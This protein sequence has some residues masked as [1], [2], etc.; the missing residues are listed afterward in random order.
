MRTSRRPG[1]AART[2]P[3]IRLIPLFVGFVGFVGVGG[4]GTPGKK[5]IRPEF[6]LHDPS[7]TR[8]TEAV[9]DVSLRRD[10][11]HVP[12]LISLLD[13]DDPAVRMA[14]GTTLKELTGHDT[15]YRPYA[16]LEERRR[17]VD[18]WRAWWAARGAGRP[19][20]PPARPDGGPA[21]AGGDR[22]R[23]P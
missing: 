1:R 9:L 3:A 11:K 17:H 5:P 7:A 23:A 8:R 13:D 15:G 14:A 6:D 21:P 18:L 2:I 16:D 20:A 12:A 22:G 19:P 4:C 10:E